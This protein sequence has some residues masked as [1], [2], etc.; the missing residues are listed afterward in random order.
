MSYHLPVSMATF[1]SL[2]HKVAEDTSQTVSKPEPGYG[3]VFRYSVTLNVNCQLP[4]H[5]THTPFLSWRKMCE[6]QPT[7]VYSSIIAPKMAVILTWDN[8]SPEKKI[9]LLI[10]S[11][12]GNKNNSSITLLTALLVLVFLFREGDKLVYSGPKSNST[13]TA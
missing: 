5:V 3:T 12:V 4:N 11:F 7:P 13:Q 8:I 6:V 2:A 9:K 1:K 10:I